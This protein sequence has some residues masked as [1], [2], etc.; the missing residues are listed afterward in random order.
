[1]KKPTSKSA[2]A[3]PKAS[4]LCG[5]SGRT[6]ATAKGKAET[7][8]KKTAGVSAKASSTDTFQV[9]ADKAKTMSLAE[10]RKSLV[11]AGIIGTNGKTHGK[12]CKRQEEVSLQYAE[13]LK[14]APRPFC[15][16]C[17]LVV[18]LGR[19]APSY[20]GPGPSEPLRN[21][22]QATHRSP[23]TMAGSRASLRLKRTG[24]S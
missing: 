1:M 18:S 16:A 15:G 9:V 13:P 5:T 7:K 20:A 22:C 2:S 21:R 17:F 12:L 4:S 23:R 19:P 3:T 14:Q 24:L 8:T 6:V 10:F 11:R